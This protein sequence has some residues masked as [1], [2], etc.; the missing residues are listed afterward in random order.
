MSCSLNLLLVGALVYQWEIENGRCFCCCSCHKLVLDQITAELE[1]LGS[2]VCDGSSRTCLSGCSGRLSYPVRL[3]Q[4]LTFVSHIALN[5]VHLY[6]WLSWCR[7]GVWSIYVRYINQCLVLEYK[8]YETNK[9]T[10]IH[11]RDEGAH[12][13][14]QRMWKVNILSEIFVFEDFCLDSM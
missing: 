9:H 6:D 12:R 10:K 11:I 8:K 5:S 3:I 14:S 2:R 13:T 7:F 1:K 4:P